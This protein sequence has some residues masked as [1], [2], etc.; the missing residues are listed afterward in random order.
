MKTKKKKMMMRK[1]RVMKIKGLLHMML[2]SQ[3]LMIS[4][5]VRKYKRR[6]KTYKNHRKKQ[7]IRVMKKLR[8]KK[9]LRNIE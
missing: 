4:T 6:M 7:K 8:E 5:L 9:S 1:K 3:I 2:F